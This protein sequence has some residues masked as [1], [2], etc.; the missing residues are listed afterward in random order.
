MQG[1]GKFGGQA[2]TTWIAANRKACIHN[3]IVWLQPPVLNKRLIKNLPDRIV[4]EIPFGLSSDS[5]AWICCYANSPSKTTMAFTVGM[6]HGPG[7][8]RNV[9]AEIVTL[10]LR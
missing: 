5:G 1:S 4:R 7:V 8:T 9:R 10:D 2:A 3:R 6:I